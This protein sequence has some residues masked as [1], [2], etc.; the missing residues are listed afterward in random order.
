MVVLAPSR[1]G[2]FAQGYKGEKSIARSSY[3]VVAK[4]FGENTHA[5]DLLENVAKACAMH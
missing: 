1:A 3:D 4:V 2:Q 5:L